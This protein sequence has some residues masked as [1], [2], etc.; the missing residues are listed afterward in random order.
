MTMRTIPVRRSGNRHNLF[1]GGDRELVMTA[2]LLAFTLI[3]AAQ[4]GLATIA[5]VVLW[6]AA[7]YV[8]RLMARKDPQLRRVY[9]RHRLYC[10]YYP[11]RSTP[12]R[13]NGPKQAR[14]Y[15]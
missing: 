15:R 2:G 14:R 11:A 12:F 13:E 8:C 6:F 1:L 9:L 7:V 5:G 10:R 3:V 4:D